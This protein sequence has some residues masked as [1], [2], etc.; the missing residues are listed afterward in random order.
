MPQIVLG[1]QFEA[2]IGDY[3]EA[4][5]AWQNRPGL[6]HTSNGYRMMEHGPA[7]LRA[8]L[9]VLSDNSDRVQEDVIL[10]REAGDPAWGL[11]QYDDMTLQ[12]AD[13]PADEQKWYNLLT[14]SNSDIEDLIHFW[15]QF[16]LNFPVVTD[17]LQRLSKVWEVDAMKVD[18]GAPLLKFKT[19]YPVLFDCMYS[20]FGTMLSNSRLCEQIHG[21]NR[22]ALRSQLGE[23]Q[24]DQQRIYSSGIDHQLKEERRNM[25]E[26]SSRFKS[27]NKKAA[28][29]SVSAEVPSVSEISKRGRR[30]RN[31]LNLQAQMAE[32][33]VRASSLRRETLTLESV[34]EIAANTQLTNDASYISN[35]ETLRRREAVRLMANKS[36]WENLNPA[37]AFNKTVWAA[38]KCLPLLDCSLDYSRL[39][40]G[41]QTATTVLS[42][43]DLT[44]KRA[45]MKP[46]GIKPKDDGK[47]EEEEVVV[48]EE[49]EEVV[50]VEEEEGGGGGGLTVATTR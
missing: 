43:K 23:E 11:Y 31:R 28:K 13:R 16:C 41:R 19:E 18:E 39:L 47:E 24:T 25:N 15:R 21:M 10:I 12:K 14:R 7:F 34:Q 32:E 30:Y 4:T 37:S 22:H 40:S 45:A 29:H 38:W 3:F 35:D 2:E 36:Y 8:V 50:V 49:E 20:V 42:C 44:T 17:D 48:V 6:I 5:T 33:D 1:L 46:L 27:K 26:S 9:S